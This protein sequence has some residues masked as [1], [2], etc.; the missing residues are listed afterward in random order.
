[1]CTT[2]LGGIG[3]GGGRLGVD[4]LGFGGCVVIF[5]GR[6]PPLWFQ[7]GFG[8]SFHMVS[9]T[10]WVQVLEG[11]GLWVCRPSMHRLP[12]R[13]QLDRCRSWCP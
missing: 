7:S 4:G 3:G 1:M 13:V 10:V 2:G 5:D 8:K 11:V 12:G 9:S 6:P